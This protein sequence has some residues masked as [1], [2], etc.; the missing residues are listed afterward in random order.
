MYVCGMLLL[1]AQFL[2]AH[3]HTLL[4]A[5]LVNHAAFG[6]LKDIP[7]LGGSKCPGKSSLTVLALS[8]MK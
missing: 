2:C 4:K 8:Y 3:T 6:R 1:W 7:L 5:P